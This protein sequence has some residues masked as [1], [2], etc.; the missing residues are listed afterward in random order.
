M[1]SRDE[2][3]VTE[4]QRR[5]LER[6]RLNGSISFAG[7]M[8]HETRALRLLEKKGL[9]LWVGNKWVSESDSFGEW[10]LKNE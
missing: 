3:T 6:L 7:T 1:T 10:R 4:F 9:V 5:L 8:R 2:P